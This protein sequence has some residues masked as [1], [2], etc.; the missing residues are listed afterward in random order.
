[1][2]PS[3]AV[4]VR[5]DIPSASAPRLLTIADQHHDRWQAT[6][7]GQRLEPELYDGWSQGFALPTDGG[8]LVVG[9]DDGNRQ[10]LLWLQLAAV[11]VALVLALPSVRAVDEVDDQAA[12]EPPARDRPVAVGPGDPVGAAR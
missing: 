11:I 4:G 9:Y 5:T 3:G 8:L 2:L 7:D 6:L 1:M 12:A 10:L